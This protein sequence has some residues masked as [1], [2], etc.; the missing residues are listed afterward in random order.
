MHE[1]VNVPDA[2]LLSLFS[3]EKVKSHNTLKVDLKAHTLHHVC[4]K[5]ESSPVEAQLEIHI[6]IEVV[7]TFETWRYLLLVLLART[8]SRKLFGHAS[9]CSQ[10]WQLGHPDDWPVKTE[11]LHPPNLPHDRYPGLV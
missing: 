9:C 10:C 11:T 8:C 2:Y 1:C 3:P 7:R 4:G 6:D 5:A